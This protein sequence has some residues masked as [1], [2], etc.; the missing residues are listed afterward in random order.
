MSLPFL[1]LDLENNI[2]ESDQYTGYILHGT[3][4]VYQCSSNLQ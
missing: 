1:M 3:Y 2:R 4:P